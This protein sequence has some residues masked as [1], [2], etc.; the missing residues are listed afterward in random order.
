MANPKR[1]R[2]HKA[3]PTQPLRI[4][5][6]QWRGRKVNFDALPGLRPT[7][8]RFREML[9]NWLMHEIEG[10][11]CL[12]LFA[13]SGALGFE[14]LSRGAKHVTF[15]EKAP[16]AAQ[17]IKGNLSTLQCDPSR[18]D[19]ITTDALQWLAQTPKYPIDILFLDPPFNEDFVVPILESLFTAPW[20]SQRALIYIE[21]ESGLTLPAVDSGWC[22]RKEKIHKTKRFVLLQRID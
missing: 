21:G 10:R 11:T 3:T 17:K 5:G 19:V 7:Q 18:Y 9:F 6:G 1:K 8:D 16:T 15:I 20:L 12:D 14:S 2:D 22:I 13:G 4:I